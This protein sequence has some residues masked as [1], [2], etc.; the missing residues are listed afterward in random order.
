MPVVTFDGV[1]VE[2]ISRLRYFGIHFDRMLT[3]PTCGNNSVSQGYGCKG[4]WTLPPPTVS[5]RGAQWLRT[6]PSNNSADRSAEAGQ[7]AEWS[8][9]SHTGNHQGHTHWDHEVHARRPTSANQTECGAGLSILQ[10]CRKSPQP[11]PWSCERHKDMQTGTG[12]S[13]MGQA[14]D[15]ILQVSQPTELKQTKD[16]ERYPKVSGISVRHSC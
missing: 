9:A 11:T 14:E 10:C 5:K 6:G 1:V 12:K 16:W 15:S 8:N 2:W 3:K 4:Y 7:S 13:G